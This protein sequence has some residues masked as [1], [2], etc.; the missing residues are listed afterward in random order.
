MS[1]AT[2]KFTPSQTG[3]KYFTLGSFLPTW[4]KFYVTTNTSGSDPAAHACKGEY[5][6]TNQSYESDIT[7]GSNEQ[8]LTG[9]DRVI[10][11]QEW[12]GSAFV[13][14]LEAQ[15]LAFTV[16]GGT[17]NTVKLNMIAAPGNY[18]VTLVCGN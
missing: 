6:G 12:N 1:R 16:L 10:K 11:H 2:Y 4:G 17:V 15:F 3:T 8:S 13:Y 5:D 7:Q 18:Q 14:P 9:T